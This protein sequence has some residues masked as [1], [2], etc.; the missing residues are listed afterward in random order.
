[1]TERQNESSLI[2]KSEKI[3]QIKE[4]DYELS[5][6]NYDL[7]NYLSLLNIQPYE[8]INILIKSG[9][10]KWDKEYSLP[11]GTKLRMI[12]ENC[13]NGGKD[14]KVTI[15]IS[16]KHSDYDEDYKKEFSAKNRLNIGDD[17]IVE[18]TGI[19]FIEKINDLRA[20]AT[21]SAKVG[22]FSLLGRNPIFCLQ[23]CTNEISTS[24]FIN[25]ASSSVGTVFINAHVYFSKNSESQQKEIF[26]VDTF[27]AQNSTGNKALV[28]TSIDNTHLGEGI[29]FR[30]L[31][32]IEYHDKINEKFMK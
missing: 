29:Y 28:I 20:V 11:K 10:Y 25:V 7:G 18:I 15:F 32:N 3:Y 13:K 8:I 16:E 30:K 5:D 6:S 23:Q 9:I 19:N 26:V 14:N 4:K 17:S 31:D 22:I 24:P 1:M 2:P 21:R 12:G 27:T